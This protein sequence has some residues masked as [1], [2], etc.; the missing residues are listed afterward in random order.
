MQPKIG[1]LYSLKRITLFLLNE[2]CLINRVG[3]REI[4]YPEET[5]LMFV[6]KRKATRHEYEWGKVQSISVFLSPEGF[7]INGTYE[8]EHY[9]E[10]FLKK[11]N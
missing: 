1:K 5:I 10:R 2:E 11:A 3:S 8:L 6:G 7:I 4:I 9:P